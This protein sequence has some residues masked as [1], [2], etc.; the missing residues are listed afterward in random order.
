M[1]ESSPVGFVASTRMGYTNTNRAEQSLNEAPNG[2]SER[3]GKESFPS[4]RSVRGGIF[5]QNV[6]AID[7]RLRMKNRTEAESKSIK[8]TDPLGYQTIC[9]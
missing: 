8:G 9:Q 2:G 3:V 1:K 5:I 7:V 4:G 6:W